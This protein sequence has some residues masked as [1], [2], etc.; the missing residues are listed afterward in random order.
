MLISKID[1]SFQIFAE[2]TDCSMILGGRQGINDHRCEWLLSRDDWVAG[3][4]RNTLVE[5]I[6]FLRVPILNEGFGS[7]KYDRKDYQQMIFSF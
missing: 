1:C 2:K 5:E 7:L 4:Y 6:T 3:N